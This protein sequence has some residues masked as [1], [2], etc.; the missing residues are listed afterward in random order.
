ML[1]KT[2]YISFNFSV[3]FTVKTICR[4]STDNVPHSLRLFLN[5]RWP[6]K[7]SISFNLFCFSNLQ[8][9][10]E[11]WEFCLLLD[12]CFYKRLFSD[13]HKDYLNQ[14][15]SESSEPSGQNMKFVSIDVSFFI[16]FTLTTLWNAGEWLSKVLLLL[17]KP[18]WLLN[19]RIHTSVR[20]DWYYL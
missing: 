13:R 14:Q 8:Q 18:F 16:L 2:T 1:V 7:Q 20:N 9:T 15:P 5:Q 10:F 3:V 6:L 4:S 12:T 17:T 19:F 11:Q